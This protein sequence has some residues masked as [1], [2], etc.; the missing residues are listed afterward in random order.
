MIFLA[1]RICLEGPCCTPTP[2]SRGVS[3]GPVRS[4]TAATPTSHL[5]TEGACRAHRSLSCIISRSSQF[6][7][8]GSPHARLLPPQLIPGA[9]S[10]LFL[11]LLG[12]QQPELPAS[13]L[14]APLG[15]AS[16]GNADSCPRL[17][18]PQGGMEG[19][20]ESPSLRSC[21]TFSPGFPWCF[22]S[23][24]TKALKQTVCSLSSF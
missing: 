4:I 6:S 13:F 20:R 8:A 3:C 15:D 19:S 16:L 18:D 5:H 10:G 17:P 23:V 24:S 11:P 1:C 22:G 12:S 9:V 21:Y 14:P 7:V 2:L